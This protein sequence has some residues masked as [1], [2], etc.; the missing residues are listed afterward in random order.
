MQSSLRDFNDKS[1][2]QKARLFCF[3][4]AGGGVAHYARWKKIIDDSI[5]VYAFNLP[6]REDLFGKPYLTD[7]LA[8]IKDAA[9]TIAGYEDL[10]IILFGHSFGGLSAYF[11]NLYLNQVKEIYPQHIYISARLPPK[12]DQL[13][14]IASLN[15]EEFLNIIIERYQGMPQQILNDPDMLKLFLPIV[16]NDFLLYEQFPD[17]YKTFEE[18]AVE[19]NL[20]TIKYD[21]DHLT[22]DT[23]SHWNKLTKRNYEHINLPG[24]HFKIIND[25]EAIVNKINRDFE[26]LNIKNN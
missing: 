12:Q 23:I 8:F 26:A 22:N 10:P 25:W 17:V 14:S 1:L 3:P 19:N 11:V 6:G 21:E 4:Y 20:T 15:D 9:E 5:G 18:K 7:Y 24:D 16:K 2:S 13:K